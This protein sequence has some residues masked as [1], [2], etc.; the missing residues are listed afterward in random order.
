VH[1][2][3][4][5]GI[6]GVSQIDRQKCEVFLLFCAAELDLRRTQRSLAGDQRASGR[7]RA[8]RGLAGIVQKN[9]ALHQR[10]AR[11]FRHARER[12][13]ISFSEET[14]KILLVVRAGGGERVP[15]G[16]AGACWGG[17]W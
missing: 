1:G 4:A 5:R 7:I 16:S 9:K 17:N 8:R 12:S 13:A 10:Y 2:R 14:R 6:G 11:G 15:Q 3:A